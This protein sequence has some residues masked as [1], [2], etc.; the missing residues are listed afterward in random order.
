MDVLH[1]TTKAE[2]G[3]ARFRVTLSLDADELDLL[4]WALDGY[5]SKCPRGTTYER[6]A[7][8][9]AADLMK[10][11]KTKDRPLGIICESDQSDPV[12]RVAEGFR[13]AGYILTQNGGEV[14]RGTLDECRAYLHQNTPFTVDFNLRERGYGLRA[15]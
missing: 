15:I 3:V 6:F 14:L 11:Y 12:A 13:S 5:L 1:K 9:L 7:K 2:T 4:R 10:V 8:D